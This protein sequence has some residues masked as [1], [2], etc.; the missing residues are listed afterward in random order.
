M[1]DIVKWLDALLIDKLHINPEIAEP[2]NT[3]LLIV[4]M[5]LIAIGTNWLIQSLFR[6][7]TKR[8]KRLAKSKWH[9]FL[10]KRKLGHHLLLLLPG[11]IL[12]ILPYIAFGTNTELIRTL[13]RFDIAY[14]L[15]VVI[16]ILNALMFGFL[17]FYMTT[18]KNRIRPLQ[19]LIQGLQ[20]I[21]YFVGAIIIIAV[22]IDKSP[23]VL[24]TGLGASAAVLMLIFKDSILGFVAGVQLAQNDMIKLGDWIQMPDGSA[25]G[26]VEEIT[27]NTVKVRNW[28]NT[29]SMIP[30]Y[31]LV[32]TPFKNWR[33][34][35][36]SGGRRADKC[37]YLD[38]N[39]LEIYSP[40]MIGDIMK[41]VPALEAPIRQKQ[42]EGSSEISTN[43]GIYRLYIETYL[44]THPY[45]NP[46]LDI[47]VTQK[48][49]TAYGLP[50]EVYFFTKEKAWAEY[51]R[52]QSDI[53]DH[54]LT[55]VPEFGLKL[56]Q[57]P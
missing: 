46:G 49:A 12:Y 43:V 2:A 33:G 15:I 4:A 13:H 55:I 6:W 5:L 32:T 57:R 41:A 47:I 11:L 8:S 31:T 21:L 20:V 27:L 54:L 24:L 56:Y 9:H 23:T 44:R 42:A 25:N 48:E 29:L 17:D 36:E 37:I 51:E 53:F 30:P 1:I 35:T 28:D 19:G 39:T 22:L 3:A 38:V 40:D 18:D 16:M 45:V 50:I 52:Q 34:M 10:V 7:F 14:M 26:N